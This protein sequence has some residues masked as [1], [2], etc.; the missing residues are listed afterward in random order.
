[1]YYVRSGV[2]VYEPLFVVHTFTL[3]GKEV[4]NGLGPMFVSVLLLD[5]VFGI[6]LFGLSPCHIEMK[7]LCN[8]VC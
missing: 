2:G 5:S 4:C 6:S 7:W 8:Y 1:M 3:L